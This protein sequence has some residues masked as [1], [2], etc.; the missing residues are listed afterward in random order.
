[1][2]R[3]PDDARQLARAERREHDA[4]GFDHM[5]AVH[6]VIERPES[7]IE[8]EDA[9]AGHFSLVRCEGRRGLET[10]LSP[11]RL[12]GRR[13]SEDLRRHGV[14]SVALARMKFRMTI[15]S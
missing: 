8:E 12:R 14:W 7:G 2:L 1:M 3:L 9:G 6:P 11:G 15:R 4:A 13:E 5:L 10:H